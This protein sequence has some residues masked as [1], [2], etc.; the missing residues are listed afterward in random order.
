VAHGQLDER[1]GQMA[2]CFLQMRST[3][4]ESTFTVLNKNLKY[5]SGGGENLSGQTVNT[6][7]DEQ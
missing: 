1:K 4:L 7:D 3:V 5:Q 6:T 2:N